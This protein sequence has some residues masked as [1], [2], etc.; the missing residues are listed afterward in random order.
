MFTHTLA[1]ALLC[2]LLSAGVT[3]AGSHA[4]TEFSRLTPTVE[5]F[6]QRET[7][8]VTHDVAAQ[9]KYLFYEDFEAPLY[10]PGGYFEPWK[11]IP[12]RFIRYSLAFTSYALANVALI[13]PSLRP[14]AAHGIDFAIRK[15][16]HKRI[17]QDWQEDGFGKQDVEHATLEDAVAK[18]NIMYKGHLNT[19]YGLFQ[20]LSKDTRYQEE[21][22]RLTKN[23]VDELE[24]NPYAGIV[25]E[26]DNYFPQCNT[27][28]YLSLFLY[29]RLHGTSY[30]EKHTKVW[31]E[32]L[33]KHLVDPQTGTLYLSYHP[34]LQS[35]KPYISAYTTAWSLV[36]IHGMDPAFAEKHY[37]DFKRTFLRISPDGRKAYVRETNDTE[38]QDSL[39]SCFALLLAKEMGDIETFDRLMNY[40]EE[41]AKP[42]FVNSQ[43]VYENKTNF[44]LPELLLWA[45]VHV[46]TRA[47]IEADW[48]GAQQERQVRAR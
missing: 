21:H 6:A 3:V 30:G 45:K 4:A 16:K 24:A 13:D 14:L 26:P 7:G 17:W 32:W 23:I 38:D 29:D 41:Q 44:L 48:P 12:D 34:S 2:A 36:F 28:T 47:L 31:T 11:G 27:V 1:L 5:Y 10:H 20:L 37:P 25:C 9:I 46:G 39:A 42:K 18:G 15:M 40:L 19:M 8:K 43:L 33:E 22:K 35:V